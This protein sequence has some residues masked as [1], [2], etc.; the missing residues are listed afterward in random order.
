MPTLAQLKKKRGAN[1]AE[2]QEKIKNQNSGNSRPVD[3]RIWK[4]KFNKDKGKGTCIVRFLTPKEGDAFVEL[5]EYQFTGSGGNYW[6]PARVTLGLE[7][8]I[9]IAAINGFRK[10]KAE[11]NKTLKE[12]MIKLLPKSKFYAN[13]MVIRD[14]EVPDNEGKVFIWQYGPK[15]QSFINK[16]IN[17]EFEDQKSMNP[18]DYWEGADFV[19]RMISNEIP[20]KRTGKKIIVPNY[21]NSSFSDPSEF[22]DGDDEKIE[23]IF[24]L[25]V[26]LSEFIDPEL[27]PEFDK[28]AE[29]FA[30]VWGK[31]YDWLD[32]DGSGVANSIEKENQDKQME[33]EQEEQEEPPSSK[34]PFET[35]NEEN[36]EEE[37][38]DNPL[39]R[40]R[41]KLKNQ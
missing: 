30:R 13:V 38:E 9:Q 8:P 18:F 32:P 27:F 29:D 4:P 17:P 16:A 7:D 39:Q 28:V 36:E 5:K 11:D 33:E 19:I 15:V 14:E 24:N 6:S 23:E 10:A 40:F 37:D 34:P 31:P 22:M 41:D 12:H 1:V 35:D 2:L 25:T 26:D 20:D 3:P 21:D